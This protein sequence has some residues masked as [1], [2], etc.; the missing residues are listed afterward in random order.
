MREHKPMRNTTPV[1]STINIYIY[2]VYVIYILHIINIFMSF[3]GRSCSQGVV[4]SIR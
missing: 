4:M 1:L 2:T 3:E